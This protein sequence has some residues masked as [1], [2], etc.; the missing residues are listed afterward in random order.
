M[1]KKRKAGRPWIGKDNRT[2]VRIFGRVNASNWD[3]ITKAA[4]SSGLCRTKWMLRVLL[5]AVEKQKKKD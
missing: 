3:A 4:R 2:P 1:G 5:A